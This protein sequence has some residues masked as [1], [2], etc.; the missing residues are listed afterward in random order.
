[1]LKGFEYTAKYNLGH[2]V[3][4]V[5]YRSFEGRYHYKKISDN[6]R[7]RLRPMYERVFN[8]YHNRKGLDAPLHGKGGAEAARG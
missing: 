4:Y 2:E 6:S 5:P 7:G 3:P 1:M 8:H